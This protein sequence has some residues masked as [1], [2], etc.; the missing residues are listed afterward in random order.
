MVKLDSRASWKPPIERRKEVLDLADRL[1]DLGTFP[2]QVKRLRC[3]GLI[4]TVAHSG[5]RNLPCNQRF[6]PL[7]R[8]RWRQREFRKWWPKIASISG[9]QGEV[10]ALT[11]TR[12]LRSGTLVEQKTALR[13]AAARL[14]HRQPW[15][16][17][18]GFINQVGILL[19][20]EI[21]TEGPHNGLPHLH[22][23]VVGLE[24]GL[25]LAAAQWL[26]DTWLE[27]NP[28]ASPLGQDFSLCSGPK[29]FGAWLN[30]I[31][32]GFTIAPTWSDERLEAML[33]ALTDGSHRLTS[34]GLL[35][36]RKG[37]PRSTAKARLKT[38]QAASV[39]VSFGHEGI[40]TS[41]Q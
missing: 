41:R 32:K 28:D 3:C 2:D 21:G 24:P 11:L 18:S 12:P 5:Q 4:W 20:V 33:E 13:K 10:V 8:P 6:C 35:S 31:L 34:S 25:A 22:L 9:Q 17:A 39:E 15:K 26:R 29:G 1:E 36:P 16:G 37:K 40:D 14:F 19:V 7:C 30:Y 27:V 23:L 38:H